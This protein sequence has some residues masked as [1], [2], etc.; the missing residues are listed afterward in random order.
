MRPSMRMRSPLRAGAGHRLGAEVVLED[1]E[2]GLAR[3]QA[4]MDVG[5]GGLRGRSPAGRLR[6]PG[7]SPWLSSPAACSRTA[8]SGGRA[9]RCPSGRPACAAAPRRR[10]RACATSRSRASGSG[11]VAM[12]LS[13][14]ISGS[15]SKYIWVI[16]RCTKPEPKTEKCMCAGRQSFS[17]VAVRV[18]A[19]LHGAEVPAALV[20][21]QA[22][23]RSRRNWGRSAPRS[24][25][26]CG[27]SGRR[28]WPATPRPA[29]SAPAARCRPAR[30]RGG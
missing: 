20:V 19:G 10:G 27:G 5:A 9:A 11:M 23:G 2:A 8:W 16:R 4:D 21:G 18:G 25:R 13:W 14:R 15:P 12:M 6:C 3:D 22:S 24:G 30:G 26:S 28:R 1:V 7:S 17:A 29:R